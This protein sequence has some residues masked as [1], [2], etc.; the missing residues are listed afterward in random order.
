MHTIPVTQLVRDSA[1]YN[2]A[3]SAADLARLS[4]LSLA[5]ALFLITGRL[6]V[7]A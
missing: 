2:G 6:V 5:E 3:R 4:G 7:R 1:Q